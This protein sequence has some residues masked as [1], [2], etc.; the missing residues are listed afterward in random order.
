MSEVESSDGKPNL[1]PILDMVFQLI[2]FFM[3]VCSFKMGELDQDVKLPVVGSA[4]PAKSTSTGVLVLNVKF[5]KVGGRVSEHPGL[6]WYNARKD[7]ANVAEN[8]P[9]PNIEGFIRSQAMATALQ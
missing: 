6:F 4:K 8:A 7:D 2:T 9:D 5:P 1:T 3:L